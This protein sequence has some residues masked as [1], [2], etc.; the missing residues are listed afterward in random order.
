MAQLRA[1]PNHRGCCPG[2]AQASSNGQ[3]QRGLR[4]QIL[5]PGSSRVEQR[6]SPDELSIQLLKSPRQLRPNY[7]S[8]STLNGP[9]RGR[10]S[11]PYEV[12][13]SHLQGCLR[14]L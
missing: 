2:L 14:S 8:T 9:E 6:L 1:Q 11:S 13:N 4:S 5:S 12:V 10:Q 7:S 3:G